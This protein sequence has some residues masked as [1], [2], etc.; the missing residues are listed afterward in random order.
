[1]MGLRDP[2]PSSSTPLRWRDDLLYQE[3]KRKGK[4]TKSEERE[5]NLS[6]YRYL[7]STQNIHNVIGNS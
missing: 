1:M 6:F 4:R 7:K 2:P 5:K 3:T